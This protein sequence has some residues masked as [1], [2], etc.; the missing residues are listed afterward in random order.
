M[1]AN[2]FETPLRR[3]EASVVHAKSQPSRLHGPTADDWNFHVVH[4]IPGERTCLGC[5][6]TFPGGG[7]CQRCGL[8]EPGEKRGRRRQDRLPP[9]VPTEGYLQP[10]EYRIVR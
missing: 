4:V 1:L 7:Y 3:I 10:D 6:E 2:P 5:G 8:P 9:S